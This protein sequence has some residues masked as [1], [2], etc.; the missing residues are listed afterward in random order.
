MQG[1]GGELGECVW[2]GVGG[3]LGEWGEGEGEEEGES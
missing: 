1:G 2:G 3:K